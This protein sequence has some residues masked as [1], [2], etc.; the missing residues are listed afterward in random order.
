MRVRA[1]PPT[2]GL[3][4]TDG[5]G[6]VPHSWFFARPDQ[7]RDCRMGMGS[8]GLTPHAPALTETLCLLSR[9][10]LIPLYLTRSTLNVLRVKPVKTYR[11]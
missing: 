9:W 7:G 1:L 5:L 3:S 11:G 8:P 10:L 4:F 2:I 6:A